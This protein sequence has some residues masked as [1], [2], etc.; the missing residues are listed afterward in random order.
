MSKK[1]NLYCT[2][3]DKPIDEVWQRC[4]CCRGSANGD[5][6]HLK[7][8]WVDE[9]TDIG[10]VD[11]KQAIWKDPITNRLVETSVSEKRLHE[12]AAEYSQKTNNG[13]CNADAMCGYE[14]GY[15]AALSDSHLIECTIKEGSL[16]DDKGRSNK[17][18]N[19]DEAAMSGILNKI[20]DELVGRYGKDAST[21]KL[22]VQIRIDDDVPPIV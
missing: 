22:V 8:L 17:I 10:V 11:S 16:Y 15:K 13:I 21:H 3:N 2:Y 5:C 20:T 4:S 1:P 14:N 7:V 6:P 19:Y 9:N 12:K 18:L